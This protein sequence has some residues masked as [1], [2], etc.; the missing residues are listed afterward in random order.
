MRMG[1]Y[2]PCMYSVVGRLLLLIRLIFC[3]QTK[4]R[5]GLQNTGPKVSSLMTILLT[6]S[7]D[8][9]Y[10]VPVI[11]IKKKK[12]TKTLNPVFLIDN[13]KKKTTFKNNTEIV[14][15]Y[16]LPIALFRY[17]RISDGTI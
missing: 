9:L 11:N 13:Q 8:I 7:F 17:L 3:L 4:Y 5:M 1:D 14:F 16:P 12:K 2:E 6:L 15:G 10:N